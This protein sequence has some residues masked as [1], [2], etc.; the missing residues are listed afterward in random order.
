MPEE[1]S[2]HCGA[3]KLI[4]GIVHAASLKSESNTIW[5]AGSTSKL[6]T[7]SVYS[8]NTII[9]GYIKYLALLNR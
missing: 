3:P 7:D 6:L 5:P 1:K 8:K 4:L 9:I 2:K